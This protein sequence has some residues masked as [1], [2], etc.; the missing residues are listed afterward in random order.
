MSVPTPREIVPPM[1]YSPHAGQ[2]LTRG[3]YQSPI[4]VVSGP[5]LS[6]ARSGIAAETR[7]RGRS[8]APQHDEMQLPCLASVLKGRLHP[9]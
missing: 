8:V 6:F 5:K 1:R 3:G 9:P 7:P 4:G 2:R